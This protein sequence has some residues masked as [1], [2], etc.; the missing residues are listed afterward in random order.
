MVHLNVWY[1]H[2]KYGFQSESTLYSCLNEV[3]AQDER[4]ILILSDCNVSRTHNHLVFKQTL[5]HL[6]KLAKLLSFI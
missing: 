4:D 5:N 2:V 6:G 3:L 1:Y